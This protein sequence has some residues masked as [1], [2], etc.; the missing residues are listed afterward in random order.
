VRLGVLIH[1]LYRYL[2]YFGWLIEV[3]GAW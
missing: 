2:C 1:Y 3:S